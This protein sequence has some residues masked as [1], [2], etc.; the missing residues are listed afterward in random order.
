MTRSLSLPEAPSG[1]GLP[2]APDPVSPRAAF[3]PFTLLLR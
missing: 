3:P 2:G 1:V